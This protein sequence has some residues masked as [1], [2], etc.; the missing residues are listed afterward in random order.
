MLTASGLSLSAGVDLDDLACHRRVQLGH[1]LHR[2][3]RAERLARFSVRADLRQLDVD[4]VAEL[5]LGVVGDADLAAVARDSIHSWSLVYFRSAGYAMTRRYFRSSCRTA[6]A[7]RARA[8]PPAAD[9][10]VEFSAGA[11]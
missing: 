2:L 5:L 6:S 3:D 7:R 8:E 4:D 10:D 9:V 1:G 11:A